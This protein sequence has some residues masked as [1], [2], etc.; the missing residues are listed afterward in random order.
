MKT[1]IEV[2]IVIILIILNLIVGG[3]FILLYFTINAP[4]IYAE[5]E[6]TEL[7]SEELKLNT[8]VDVSNDNSFDLIVKNVIIVSETKDGDDFTRY[9]F[10]G[11]SVPSND[12]KTFVSEDS[13]TLLGEIPKV[14]INT[15]TADV[16]VKFLGFIEKIVP[17]KAVIVLSVENFI[18]D[19]SIPEIQI[20]GGI[21][22]ITEEGLIF[23]ADIEISNPS[24]I[25]LKID[26]IIV[27]LK[28]ED[29]DSV[30]SITLDG[31]TLEPKGTLNLDV[32]G[33]LEYE[34]LNSKNVIIDVN[35]KATI[36]VAGLSQSLNLSTTAIID[37]PNLS[38]LLNLNDDSFDFSLFGEFK[39]RLRGVI[40]AVDFKVFNPSNIP[41][42]AQD[43]KCI[44]YGITGENKK[45]IAEKDMDN[46]IVPSK[47]EVCIST[48][49]TIP[50]LKLI[51]SGT[52]RIF[53]EWFGIRLEGNFAINR[54]TQMIP[55]SINGYVDPFFF[56]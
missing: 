11:G 19:I 25:E 14:L 20:Q 35:G 7:T 32:S 37:I 39:I 13:I 16:G 41:L 5:I 30:G 27:D 34:A 38:D 1:N 52:G 43:I 9:T 17:V 33:I 49:I 24:D 3:F 56:R 29:E 48:Q 53:P 42:E 21:D 51:F 4:D 10:K 18:N 54:T 12:K 44:I 31:G 26:D 50:Y 6:I 47:N 55:I 45:L 23:A 22:E 40:T 28:T 36:N 15:I 46:C 2:I 8:L